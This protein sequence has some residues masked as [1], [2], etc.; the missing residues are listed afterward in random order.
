MPRGFLAVLSEPG[1]VTLDEFHDW[2][3]NEHVPLRLNHIPAFLTGARFMAA[4]GGNPG[5]IALYDIDSTTTFTDPSY[6]R[7]R[8]NRSPREAALVKR[9]DILDRR[10]CEVVFESEVEKNKGSSTGLAV[11][12]PTQWIV[13]HGLDIDTQEQNEN[14]TALAEGWQ[15]INTVG[16]GAEGLL[17]SR[18]FRCI[19]GLKSGVRVA[20]GPEAQKIPQYFVLHD[21]EPLL[22]GL[23]TLAANKSSRLIISEGREWQI[24]R[25]YPCLAQGNLA[26]S[27]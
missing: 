4:D 5:W 20:P 2:Y 16:A 19:V 7:L 8:E 24:Y 6:T 9:L 11:G 22:S 1:E 25:A 14:T 21:A 23:K 27:S 3:N 10:T 18:L 13:T 15:A 26:P 17:R 12:N